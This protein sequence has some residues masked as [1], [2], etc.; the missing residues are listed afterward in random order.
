MDAQSYSV[1][2]ATT[3]T[4]GYGTL[5]TSQPTVN[6]VGPGVRAERVRNEQEGQGDGNPNILDPAPS[7]S[8][9]PT[10][11]VAVTQR[12]E[13]EMEMHPPYS[14][15]ELQLQ[16]DLVRAISAAPVQPVTVEREDQRASSPAV[17]MQ[18]FFTA[19]T[20][21]ATS[22]DQP[23]T[24]WTTRVTEFLRTTASRGAHGVDRLLDNLGLQHVHVGGSFAGRTVERTVQISPPQQLPGGTPPPHAPPVPLSWAGGHSGPSLFAPE[25]LER[26]RQARR[27]HPLI[28]GQGSEVGSDNSSRL[29]AEVQRQLEEYAARYRDQVEVLQEEVRQLRDERSRMSGQRPPSPPRPPMALSMAP[30]QQER[31]APPPP[32]F[33]P[34]EPP[35]QP[36]AERQSG[37]L[38]G[39]ATVPGGQ[40]GNPQGHSTVPGGQAGNLQGHSTVPGGQAGNLQGHS[41]VPGGQ[42]G[43]LPGHSTVPGGQAGNLQGHSAVPGG[44]A[45]PGR[46]TVPGGQAGNLPGHSTV[47]GGQAG[48]LHGHSTVPGGQ[49]GNLQGHSAVPGGQAGNLLQ[50]SVVHD[51]QEQKGPKKPDGQ[52]GTVPDGVQM[53]ESSAQ[54][55]LSG[56]TPNHIALLAGGMAQL[57]KAMLQ[58]MA[59]ADKGEDRSPEAVKPGTSSL[60]SL[61]AVHAE[62]SSIDIA[63]WMEMLAAPMADLSDGSSVWWRLVREKAIEAYTRWSNAG[64]MEKLAIYPERDDS[65]EGGRWSRVNSR[66]AS[67]IVLALH[68][69][70]RSE[71]VARRLT[72]S[73]VSLL[74][75]LMTLYQP[76]GQ[77]ERTR[78]LQVVQLRS[79]S[80]REQLKG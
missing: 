67:M 51:G 50:R 72:G 53:P 18:E 32:S 75:R 11:G 31:T 28:Y 13:G 1:N 17:H 74:F 47:P 36:E 9:N 20:S 49:A 3:A 80:H 54:Q 52:S 71:M 5:G 56:E 44:Q 6:G 15:G 2:P 19:E 42:A 21:A 77:A 23:T 38:Q 30:E 12:L 76:G 16:D 78:I 34:P 60:P 73:A 40:A 7:Q 27:D 35:R 69:S 33:P 55:W 65:L 61:P 79:R 64:P 46:S 68:E 8:V 63:D 43:N 10:S 45:G 59:S 62:T 57:Q 26:M 66:A 48:N 24:R 41:A 25:Q 22:P 70:V 39:H 58:Q 14:Q 29:Q 37:N 4:G